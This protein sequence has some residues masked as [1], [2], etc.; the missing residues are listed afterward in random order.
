MS[1]TVFHIEKVSFMPI[2][3][4]L[5]LSVLAVSAATVAMGTEVRHEMGGPHPRRAGVLEVTAVR[6]NGMAYATGGPVIEIRARASHRPAHRP[7]PAPSAIRARGPIAN[8]S[9]SAIGSGVNES[10]CRQSLSLQAMLHNSGP[11]LTAAHPQPLLWFELSPV[12][13]D[14]GKAIGLPLANGADA[15]IDLGG[16]VVGPG[17]YALQLQFT[18]TDAAPAVPE[19]VAASFVL[20]V[21]C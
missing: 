15:E 14:G 13:L 11:A 2:P 18:R 19:G 7:N 12:G 6:I 5:A 8:S 20:A 21:S 16:L 4:W 3:R 10:A 17:T 1:D 9:G